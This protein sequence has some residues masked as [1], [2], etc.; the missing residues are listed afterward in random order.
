LLLDAMR[1][2]LNLTASLCEEYGLTDLRQYRHNYRAIKHGQRKVQKSRRCRRNNDKQI[3]TS[4]KSY[5]NLCEANIVKVE[6][7][8]LK[9]EEIS[10][11]KISSKIL[12]EEIKKFISHAL[13]QISQIQRRVIDGEVIPHDEKVFSLFEPHTEWI[14]KGKAGVPVELGVRV[15]IMEDQHQFILHH[16][17]MEK[18]TDDKVA[19][20]MVAT[21]KAKFENLISVSLDKGFHSKENQEELPKIVDVVGLPRKGKLSKADQE[22]ESSEA[23]RQARKKHS[24][25]ESAINGLEVHGLDICPDKG[26]NGFKRYVAL[27]VLTRNIHRIG[28]IVHKRN[29]KKLLKAKKRRLHHQLVAANSPDMRQ[30]A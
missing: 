23:F 18:E 29:A 14:S 26:I 4:H 9:L 15:C 8:L 20:A 17:V 22:V 30:I 19:I 7:V 28:A 25:V 5:M 6:S 27:A 10:G 1:K 2:A 3:I 13:R 16:R 21:T 11:L 24:A 12:I